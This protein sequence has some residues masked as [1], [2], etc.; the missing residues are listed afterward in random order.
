MKFHL[1]PNSFS[2]DDTFAVAVLVSLSLAYTI[3]YWRAL[4]LLLLRKDFETND[5]ILWFLVITMAPMVGLITFW[6]LVQGRAVV[7]VPPQADEP[8]HLSKPS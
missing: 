5:R 2:A 3:L 8:T 1:G 7:Q 6:F 4:W